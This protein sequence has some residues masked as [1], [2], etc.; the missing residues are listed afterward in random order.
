MRQKEKTDLKR[1]EMPKSDLKILI[2]PGKDALTVSMIGEAHFDLD[3]ANERLDE[4]LA[5]KPK[6]VLVEAS[7]L[8]FIS[9]TGICF[10]LN[11]RKAIKHPLRPPEQPQH[12]VVLEECGQ[13]SACVIQTILNELRA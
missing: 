1:P 3:V 5:H 13:R 7:K 6:A 11:L 9:S 4:V 8:T 12:P 2:Q 10:L